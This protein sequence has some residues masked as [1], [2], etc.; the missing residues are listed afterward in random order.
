[1][2]IRRRTKPNDPHKGHDNRIK[3]SLNNKADNKQIKQ[4]IT[5]EFKTGSFQ[6]SIIL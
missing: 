2:E 3:Q 4:K 6:S 1:M 5:Y